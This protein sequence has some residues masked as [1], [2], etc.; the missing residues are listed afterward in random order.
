MQTRRC[1]VLCADDHGDTCLM[2][3]ALLN[4]SGYEVTTAEG[5][6]EAKRAMAGAEFDLVVLDNRFADGTGAGLCTWV[7]SH[8]PATPVVFYSGAAYDSDME[9]GIRAGAAAYVVKPDI[10]GLLSAVN[11][12]LRGSECAA[13]SAA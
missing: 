8:S 13:T 12:L 6:A 5:V 2:L 4:A 11:V 10:E 1:H 3:S 7:R 9:G